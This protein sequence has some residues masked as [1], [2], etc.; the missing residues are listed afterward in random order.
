LGIPVLVL[1]P[2]LLIVAVA[3]IVFGWR[4]LQKKR[5]V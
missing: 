5:G 2:I 1:L 4:Q 3:A